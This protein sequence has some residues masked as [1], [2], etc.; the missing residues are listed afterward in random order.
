MLNRPPLIILSATLNEPFPPSGDV[1]I[2]YLEVVQLLHKYVV[3]SI[4]GYAKM[5]VACVIRNP[6][7]N[8]TYTLGEAISLEG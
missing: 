3:N 4:E 6:E 8:I 5:N 1:S 7:G 2:I